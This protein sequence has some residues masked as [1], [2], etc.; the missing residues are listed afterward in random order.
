MA[1]KSTP[2]GIRN[3]NP[4][5][6]DRGSPWQGLVAGPDPRFCTFADPAYGIRAIAITLI[7]YYDK[8]K[9]DDKS[10]VDTV[11]EII[12]RW[13][14]P[15]ENNTAAYIRYVCRVM[16]VAPDE[17]VNLHLYDT[18]RPLV[19]AII[20]H[21]CGRGPLDTVNS[22]YGEDVIEEGLRRAG[23][24]KPSRAVSSV[25][26]TRETAGAT[27]TASIGLAQIAEAAPHL[28]AALQNSEQHLTSGDWCRV[29]FGLLTVAVA[30]FIAWSQIRK[31]QRG[32]M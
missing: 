21:E 3:N 10:P 23:I 16:G 18:L 22:W 1:K 27:I 4:G 6:L 14:P 20:R 25:P 32:I 29:G 2:R 19:E 28:Q 12:T 11:G 17:H 13:A 31:F 30:I 26:A 9:A 15:V 8:R 7:T 5:N 24:V